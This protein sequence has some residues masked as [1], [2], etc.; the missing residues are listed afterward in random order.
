[1]DN[2]S[3]NPAAKLTAQQ[4]LDHVQQSQQAAAG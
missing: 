3:D 2:L 4:I 1:V